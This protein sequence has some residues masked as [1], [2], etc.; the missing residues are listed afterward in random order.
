MFYDIHTKVRWVIHAIMINKGAKYLV[1]KCD[2]HKAGSLC[3]FIVLFYLNVCMIILNILVSRSAHY[4]RHHIYTMLIRSSFVETKLPWTSRQSVVSRNKICN[5]ANSHKAS[6]C[7]RCYGAESRLG[8]SSKGLRLLWIWL[9]SQE[10]W[11]SFNFEK[12]LK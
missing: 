4:V 3:L 10:C 9:V 5:E 11:N 7:K 6:C 1:S 8:S 12:I 2:Y